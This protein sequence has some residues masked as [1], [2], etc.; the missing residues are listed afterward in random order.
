[1]SLNN[2]KR[3][4]ILITN[5]DGISST[6]LKVLA[7]KLSE[8][9][10]VFI[11]APSQNQ[12]GVSSKITLD[13]AIEFVRISEN[14]FSCS[15]TPADCVISSVCHDFFFDGE[16]EKISF[17]AVFSGI[18]RGPNLGTD[19]VYSGTIAAARQAVLYNI[20]GIAVSLE[21][22]EFDYA[23]T[24]FN[25][26]GI[27]HFCAKNLDTLI[28]LCRGDLIV[29]INALSA[30]EY[31]EVVFT[32]LCKR[33]Y[34]DTVKITETRGE[35]LSG[36]CAGGKILTEGEKGCDFEAVR[37]GKISVSLL[38]ANPEAVE[39]SGTAEFKF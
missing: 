36:V 15:G 8:V 27:A 34:N 38:K 23:N 13:T 35:K 18:N 6:G 21:S 29:S 32:S 4:K 9:C 31:K 22:P 30:E 24:N 25:F 1:M 2:N 17:D 3:K 7:E 37:N 11:M 26:E 28:S 10:D 20:P 39:F 12:S 14:E 19:T 16:G 33:D 5:D